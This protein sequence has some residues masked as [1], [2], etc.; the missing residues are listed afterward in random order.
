MAYDNP[1]YSKQ[2]VVGGEGKA[3]IPNQ[4]ECNKHKEFFNFVIYLLKAF[5]HIIHM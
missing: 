3:N 4:Q 2:S 5:I 1:S